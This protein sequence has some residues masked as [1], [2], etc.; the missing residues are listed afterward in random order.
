MTETK[1]I[2]LS[3]FETIKV[4]V[5]SEESSEFEAVQV[6]DKPEI[7]IKA[8]IVEEEARR[9]PATMSP[10]RQC[11][12]FL[13]GAFL[14]LPQHYQVLSGVLLFGTVWVWSTGGANGSSQQ[15]AQLNQ[16]VDQLGSDLAEVKN[17]LDALVRSMEKDGMRNEL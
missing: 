8:P 4:A 1:P 13:S 12:K 11:V 2:H 10:F 9:K 6:E 16:K 15:I 7:E 14:L 3:L 17:L 5:S